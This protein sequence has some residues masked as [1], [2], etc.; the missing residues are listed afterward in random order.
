MEIDIYVSTSVFCKTGLHQVTDFT[1]QHKPLCNRY[2]LAT[3]TFCLPGINIKKCNQNFKTP[4]TVEE[5]IGCKLCH[6]F[7]SWISQKPV[8]HC[9]L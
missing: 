1:F 8:F 7:A 4:K 3:G 6:T 2:V 5:K 9:D